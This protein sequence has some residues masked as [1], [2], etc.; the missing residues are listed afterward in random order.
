LRIFANPPPPL[1]LADTTAAVTDANFCGIFFLDYF[2][3]EVT[4]TTPAVT[5]DN[6]YEVSSLLNVALQNDYGA[7]F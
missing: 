4:V 2:C 1:P 6:F 5:D 7:E 3:V